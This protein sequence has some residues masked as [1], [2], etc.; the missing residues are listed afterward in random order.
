M[1]G[2][3]RITISAEFLT[4]MFTPGFHRGYTVIADAIPSDAVVVDVKRLDRND[5][6]IT[7]SSLDFPQLPE[8]AATPFLVPIAEHVC[9]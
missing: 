6:E 9:T 3:R 2:F 5:I 8:M 1:P 4:S 7:I